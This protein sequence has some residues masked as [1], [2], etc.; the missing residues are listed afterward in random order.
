MKKLL[1]ILL[2]LLMIGCPTQEP[3]SPPP[4]PFADDD[5]AWCDEGCAHL[6]TLIGRDGVIGCEEARPLVYPD[7]CQ[8][9]TE[10]KSGKCINAQCIE[11]C[12]EFC[13]ATIENGRFLGPKCW[14]T[15]NSCEEI[16]TVCRR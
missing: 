5:P 9:D 6:R 13:R 1:L 11:T 3:E 16:E 7:A 2:P 12:E 8:L 10:C 4:A 15:I 14:T